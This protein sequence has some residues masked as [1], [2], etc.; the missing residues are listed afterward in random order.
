[1][2]KNIIVLLAL[3]ENGQ[4]S[5]NDFAGLENGNVRHLPKV[6]HDARKHV[7]I[8]SEEI[9]DKKTGTPLGIKYISP[10]SS[11][12]LLKD[13]IRKKALS[14]YNRKFLTKR[15]YNYILKRLNG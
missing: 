10:L 1:M 4:V 15:Q 8:Y 7:E 12:P 14:Q 9:M 5:T 11:E 13:L 2:T 6:I 3:V